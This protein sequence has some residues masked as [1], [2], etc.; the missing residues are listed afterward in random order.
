MTEKAKVTVRSAYGYNDYQLAPGD[1][2]T[3]EATGI[4]FTHHTPAKGPQPEMEWP[5]SGHGYRYR[6]NRDTKDFEWYS[7]VSGGW[8]KLEWGTKPGGAHRGFLRFCDDLRDATDKWR[9]S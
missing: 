6:F 8:R 1:T 3:I 4:G 2:L 5:D 9:A 7:E